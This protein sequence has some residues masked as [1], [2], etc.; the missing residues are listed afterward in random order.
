MR[1]DFLVLCALA[2]TAGAVETPSIG[3]ARGSGGAV[4]RV[5]GVSGAFITDRTEQ[6]GIVSAAFSDRMGLVKADSS[7]RVLDANGAVLSEADA[8]EG[9]AL[10]GF[11]AAG[12]AGIAWCAG[13][14]TVYRDGAWTSVPFDAAGAAVA[15]VAIKDTASVLV[16]LR[17]DRLSVMQIRA[18]DGAVEAITDLGPIDG[19]ML[20]FSGGGTMFVRDGL[21]VYRTASGDERTVDAPADLVEFVNMGSG[22]IQARTSSGPGLVLRMEPELRVYQL[23]EVRQ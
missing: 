4:L 23:P 11:D 19:P 1:R 18:A 7:I 21:L 14:L 10:F 5:S 16:A 8:P 22:W 9:V 15:A 3:F 20:L 13:P 12:T 6:V 2:V 17:G